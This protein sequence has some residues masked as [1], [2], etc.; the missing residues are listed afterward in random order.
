MRSHS[1]HPN[2]PLSFSGPWVFFLCW[3][4]LASRSASLAWNDLLTLA[5]GGGDGAVS[6]VTTWPSSSDTLKTPAETVASVATSTSSPSPLSSTGSERESRREGR[7]EFSSAMACVCM[8]V[9]VSG[10]LA[11]YWYPPYGRLCPVAID[12]IICLLDWSLEYG[13]RTQWSVTAIHWQMTF[14]KEI[15]PQELFSVSV[16]FISQLLPFLHWNQG[17]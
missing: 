10:V 5:K 7:T 9:R 15:G 8:F 4:A 6:V 12:W 13:R 2:R 17:L 14:W 11:W 1:P 3:L 16:A